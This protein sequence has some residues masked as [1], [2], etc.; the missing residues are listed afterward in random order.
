MGHGRATVVNGRISR[1]TSQ[2][3]E[4]GTFDMD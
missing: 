4:D 1:D 3:M 2:D